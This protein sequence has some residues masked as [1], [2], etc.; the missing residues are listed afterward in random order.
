MRAEAVGDSVQSIAL[1]QK[2]GNATLPSLFSWTAFNKKC[3]F[4]SVEIIRN[5]SWNC[6]KIF[7]EW[8][9]RGKVEQLI[10]GK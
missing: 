3:D 9:W 5:S 2:V 6:D 7:A 4:K 8:A 1:K 10:P